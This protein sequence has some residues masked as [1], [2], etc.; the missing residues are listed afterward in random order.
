[1]NRRLI[2]TYMQGSVL[3]LL[4]SLISMPVVSANKPKT[5]LEN[6][7]AK[8]LQLCQACHK[9]KGA[10]QAGSVG[11]PFIQMSQRFP[12]RDRMRD[13]INDPQ[14]AI[15]PHTMMP[16]FGRHGFLNKKEIEQVIDF[17]Y[18]L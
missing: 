8:A 16:P 12:K 6:G 7:K 14:K 10:D 17:L 3:V 9:F 4:C 1:M 13:I 2:K 18:T 11:P 5:P 15:K